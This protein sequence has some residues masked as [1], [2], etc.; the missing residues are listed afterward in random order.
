MLSFDHVIYGT[1]DLDLA[2]ASWRE[3]YGLDS[4]VGGRHPGQGTANRIVPL[5][6]SYVELMGIVDPAEAAASDYGG[7]LGPTIADGD[8]LFGWCLRTD[9]I[10]AIAVRLGSTPI[11]GA[12][13]RPDGISIRWRLAGL[14]RSRED[15]SL[16]F[17]IQW[18]VP[19]ELL[20]GRGAAN[21]RIVVDGI[22]WVEVAG[23]PA[24]IEESLDGAALDVRYAESGGRGVTRVGVRTADGEL[25][26]R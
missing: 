13:E 20:P 15:P 9:D 21:H 10:G 8:R 6:T 2:A 23:D 3:R 18:G 19:Y 5:G 24:A 26:V 16:P 25:V 14:E 1:S 7:W 4:Y 11:E 22:E 12:R 17:F